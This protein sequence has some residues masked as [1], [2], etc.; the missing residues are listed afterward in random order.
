MDRLLEPELMDDAAQAAAYANADFSA[1]NQWF[2]DQVL[3]GPL[4]GARVVDLGCGPADVLVRLAAADRSLHITGV[5]GSAPMLA[6]ARQ[7][8]AGA[9]VGDRIDLLQAHLP[10]TRPPAGAF[11]VV[12]SKDFLH[13]LPEPAT[14]WSEIRRLGRPGARVWVMDLV[15]PTS[16]EIA[17]EMV[18]RDAGG[19]DPVLKRDFYH[20]LLAAFTADEVAAQLEMA[21]LAFTVRP[22]GARHLIVEGQ[23]P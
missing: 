13:H 12:L 18:E 6:L 19:N 5:D 8:A 16:E 11:D 15:R 7:A 4:T 10:S 20:S 17:R 23:L 14:L 3:A 21:R 2:V 22:A 9:G 1:S